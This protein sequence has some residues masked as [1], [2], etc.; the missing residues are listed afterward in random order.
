MNLPSNVRLVNPTPAGRTYTLINP[1]RGGYYHFN[2]M[3]SE[4]EDATPEE[5]MVVEFN[6]RRGQ[7][8]WYY[9]DLN[10]ARELYK[11]LLK[12]GWELF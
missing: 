7:K 8:V 9:L 6:D 3:K 2:I 1:M 12:Q 5:S 11:R 4:V 10:E